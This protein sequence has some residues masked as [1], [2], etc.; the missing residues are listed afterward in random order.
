MAATVAEAKQMADSRSNVL[1]T[2]ESGVGKEIM[3]QAIH[4]ASP[5][6]KGP[7][8]AIN[9]GAIPEQLLESE[10]FGY[11]EGAFTGALRKAKSA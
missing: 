4:N 1:I 3:A 2:G 9:C 8:V 6:A 11:D 5:F 10:L 7:F